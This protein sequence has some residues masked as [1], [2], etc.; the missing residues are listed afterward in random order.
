MKPLIFA[1]LFSSTAALAETPITF[2]TLPAG[3]SVQVTFTS[4]GCFH[5]KT[6]EFTF[7]KDA[8]LTATVTQTEHGR[9]P[10][11]VGQPV[12]LGTASLSDSE[13]AGLDRLFAFYRSKHPGGC[14]TVD[15]IT[16]VQ[17]SGDTVKASESFVDGSCAT[18]DAKDLTSL[19]SIAARLAGKAKSK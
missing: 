16:A 6:Y 8:T 4:S 2:A 18:Y 15:T 13:I 5:H 7:H 11:Q 12:A 17:K 9:G 1:L 10:S 3:D 19:P 14:T